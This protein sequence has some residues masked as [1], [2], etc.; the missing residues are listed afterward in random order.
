MS[1]LRKAASLLYGIF[2]KNKTNVYSD[3]FTMLL[4]TALV[5]N[6]LIIFKDQNDHKRIKM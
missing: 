3:S 5:P 6:D 4:I 2:D 1:K